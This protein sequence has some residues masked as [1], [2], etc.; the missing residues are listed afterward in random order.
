MMMSE[1]GTFGRERSQGLPTTHKG[2]E[3]G[4]LEEW[5]VNVGL[6]YAAVVLSEGRMCA[7]VSN[8]RNALFGEHEHTDWYDV[9]VCASLFI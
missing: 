1:T 2:Q 4:G 5:E 8:V 6:L 7:S 3:V 9:E